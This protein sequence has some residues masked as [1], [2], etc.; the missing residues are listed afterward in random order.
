M[1]SGMWSL[2]RSHNRHRAAQPEGVYLDE[3]DVNSLDP[4]VAALYFPPS[5]RGGHRPSATDQP[6]RPSLTGTQL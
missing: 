5:Y 6:K 2:M 1:L 4:E 3:L